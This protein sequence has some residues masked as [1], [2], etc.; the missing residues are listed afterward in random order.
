MKS[1]SEIEKAIEDNKKA[2]AELKKQK[3]QVVRAEAL[4]K[5]KELDKADLLL[6][7]QIKEEYGIAKDETDFS[8]IRI[9]IEKKAEETVKAKQ[10]IREP[11][12]G[13]SVNV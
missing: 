11:V 7:R 13:N 10:T 5:Q 9:A 12:F 8:K 1:V 4:K 2:I 6:M 3:R